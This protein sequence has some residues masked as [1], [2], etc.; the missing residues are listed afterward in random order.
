MLET[1]IVFATACFGGALLLTLWRLVRGPDACDRI[2][3]LDTLYL[4]VAALVVLYGIA[5]RGDWLFEVAL[6]IAVLGFIGTVATARFIERGDI[7]H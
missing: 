3:A 6:L 1:A 7:V 4:N 2:L 5:T